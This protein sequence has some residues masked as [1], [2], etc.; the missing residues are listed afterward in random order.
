[1]KELDGVGIGPRSTPDSGTLK[2]WRIDCLWFQLLNIP[3][4]C[5]GSDKQIMKL[6]FFS[7]FVVHRFSHIPSQRLHSSQ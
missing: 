2:A 6:Q 3:P 4:S 5:S 7:C 1:M